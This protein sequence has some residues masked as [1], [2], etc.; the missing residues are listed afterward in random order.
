MLKTTVKI[1]LALL[2]ISSLFMVSCKDDN[3]DIHT[4]PFVSVLPADDTTYVI[5]G[6]TIGYDISVT[7]DDALQSVK[8]TSDVDGTQ[9][10]VL[11]TTL[12][13]GQTE[14]NR[15]WDY[16]VPYDLNPGDEGMLR[17]F[18]TTEFKS[19][20]VDKY[21]K[22]ETA[23]NHFTDVQLQAQ[24]DGAASAINN[25]SFYSATTNERF[26][27]DEA[28]NDDMAS[29]IDLVFI[30][31]SIYKTIEQ[32]SFQSPNE[33]NLVTLWSELPEIPF[34]YNASNKK[35][36]YFE[37]L[38]DVDWDNLDRDAIENTIGDIQPNTM[39]HDLNAGDFIGFKTEEGKY[40]IIKITATDPEHNPYT[41]A[42]V[43]FDVKVQM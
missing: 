6:D 26:T 9:H 11:D 16:D 43:T 32:M 22:V 37:R 13:S 19:I 8:L 35:M 18:A 3:Q 38:T 41:D 5:P 15:T 34:P 31:H 42:T 28:D 10:I 21:F 27:Y 30:H 36:T 17:V 40:G 39:I 14:F 24:A 29:K 12:T 20:I 23:V 33:T 2:I 1:S 7:S 25:L 4:A